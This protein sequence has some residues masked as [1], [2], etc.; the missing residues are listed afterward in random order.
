M[1]EFTEEGAPKEWIEM[2]FT[3]KQIEGWCSSSAPTIPPPANVTFTDHAYQ[4]RRKRNT[5]HRTLR[6]SLQVEQQILG[7]GV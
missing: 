5:W 3:I 2:L 1:S 7:H 4:R 6:A